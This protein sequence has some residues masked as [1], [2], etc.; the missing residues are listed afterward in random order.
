[1]SNFMEFSCDIDSAYDSDCKSVSFL[2]SDIGYV[3]S[4]TYQN[5]ATLLD[6]G[7]RIQP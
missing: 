1:M 4:L 7:N 2:T 5:H 6:L 3:V